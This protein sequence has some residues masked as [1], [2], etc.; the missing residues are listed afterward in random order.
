[1]AR[2]EEKA[3]LMLNRFIA[4]KVE[5]KRS[6]KSATLSLPPNVATSPRLTNDFNKSCQRSTTRLSR[7]RTK[8]LGN[9]DSMTL[10][11]RSISLYKR[12]HIRND[13]PLNLA[14]R[15]TPNTPL[16]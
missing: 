8:A 6:L 1:M 7:F 5:K 9:I 4:L 16:K 10:T 2:N 3:Q 15:I 12:S 14:A 11:T 13:V